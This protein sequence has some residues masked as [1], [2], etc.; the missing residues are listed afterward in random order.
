VVII[1]GQALPYIPEASEK[2]EASAEQEV[3]A[4]ADPEVESEQ[5][6]KFF[7]IY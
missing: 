7:I 6:R 2:E 1:D 5:V 3:E 4:A